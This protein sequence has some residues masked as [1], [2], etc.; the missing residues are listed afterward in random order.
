MLLGT[1]QKR[2]VG[3]SSYDSPW[4]MV[5]YVFAVSVTLFS[6]FRMIWIVL[7]GSRLQHADYWRMIESLLQ[8]DGSLSLS[9]LFNFSNVHFVAFPQFLYWL[10]IKIFAGSNI[11]LG[12][13]DVA[14]V[15]CT[16]GLLMLMIQRSSLGLAVR[17]VLLG[18]AGSIL[19]SLSG[20][21][22]FMYGMSGAAWLSANLFVVAAIYLRSLDRNRTA[23]A[24]A[25][26][27][28]ISY[29]T[30]IL[31]WPAIIVVGAVR[32]QFSQWWREWPYI[33]GLIISAIVVKTLGNSFSNTSSND[34][35][36]IAQLAAKF[37]GNS[38]GLFGS[39]GEAAGWIALVGTPLCAIWLALVIRPQEDA[40]WIALAVY[41]WGALMVITQ[42]RA[43]FMA[44]F[45][46][47]SR[48]YSLAAMTWLGFVVM[49]VLTMHTFSGFRS[50]RADQGAKSTSEVATEKSGAVQV[51]VSTILVLLLTLG[52]LISGQ[53][54]V[55]KR[56][57]RFVDQRLKEIALQLNVVD[58][59]VG[60]LEGFTNNTKAFD[61]TRRLQKLGHYPFV[62]DWNLD[63]GFL[64][65]TM[66]E[67]SKLR[68]GGKIRSV[69]SEKGLNS[70]SRIGGII[71]GEAIVSG[72]IRCIVVTDKSG[73]VVGFG[74]P[75]PKGESATKQHFTAL[76]HG[77][78]GDYKVYFFDGGE[79]PILLSGPDVARY[80]KK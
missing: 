22:N 40:G 53:S 17:I 51:F 20:A 36:L 3:K 52:A 69:G 30:G 76:A 1:D 62:E 63:C 59:S 42:G 19:L 55:E 46:Y 60:Y 14:I 32:R 78:K 41:G 74:T 15:C 80:G 67:F 50:A 47:Q 5:G 56:D 61:S 9:G 64:G 25:V 33:V 43:I 12:L 75:R 31:A 34:Y 23:L 35:F 8:P 26:L 21:W 65:E 24:A 2:S 28:T 11:A 29:G 72:S 45:S 48:Y 66:H 79:G 70:V 54:E 39:L 7:Q 16:V 27:A 6:I 49:V 4:L 58:G 57:L 71:P 13:I 77:I 68:R 18:C 38:V 10:N 73:L 44:A 37:L